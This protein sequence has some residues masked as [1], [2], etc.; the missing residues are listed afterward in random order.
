M[1]QQAIKK[2]KTAIN[3]KLLWIL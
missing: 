1:K 3:I 2:P